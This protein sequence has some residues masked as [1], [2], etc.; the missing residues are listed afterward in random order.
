M[1]FINAIFC[2]FLLIL[3]SML[4]RFMQLCSDNMHLFL[5]PTLCL[6]ILML[7]IVKSALWKLWDHPKIR[8]A[9]VI[10]NRVANALSFFCLTRR[11]VLKV[12][13]DTSYYVSLKWTQNDLGVQYFEN[14][15]VN[16][17]W[18]Q[19]LGVILNIGLFLLFRL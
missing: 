8:K 6:F 10:N 12:F 1:I 2:H 19:A 3:K 4:I 13:S 14:K 5:C 7:C 15:Y 9:S 17:F 16:N 18:S 11:T